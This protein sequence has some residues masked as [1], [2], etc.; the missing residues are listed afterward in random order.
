[1]KYVIQDLIEATLITACVTVWATLLVV[2]F[3]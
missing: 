3:S 1:M 2:V